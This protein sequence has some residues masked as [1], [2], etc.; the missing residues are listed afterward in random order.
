MHPHELCV[1]A[2]GCC[3]AA[4]TLLNRFPSPAKAR[5]DALLKLNGSCQRRALCWAGGELSQW[6]WC[7]ERLS[8]PGATREWF[9]LGGALWGS[10]VA[11]TVQQ[12][13]PQAEHHED[14]HQLPAPRSPPTPPATPSDFVPTFNCMNLI[15]GIFWLCRGL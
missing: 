7:R 6:G 9:G 11:P 14:T 8:P 15:I 12:T 3:L 2:A 1:P 5:A 13:P 4:A 10:E